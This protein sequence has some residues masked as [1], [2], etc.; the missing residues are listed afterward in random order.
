MKPLAKGLLSFLCNMNV[1]IYFSMALPRKSKAYSLLCFIQKKNPK[2]VVW[3][4][5]HFFLEIVLFSG[6][7]R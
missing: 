1:H 5:R 7:S 3:G 6:N 4:K 2:L